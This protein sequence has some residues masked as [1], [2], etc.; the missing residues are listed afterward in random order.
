MRNILSLFL[1][2]FAIQIS[3]AIFF[4]KGEKEIEK[5]LVR[6]VSIL[7]KVW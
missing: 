4:A 5:R 3:T 2:S 7:F 1:D 6:L